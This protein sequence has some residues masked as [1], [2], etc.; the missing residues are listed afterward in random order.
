MTKR[1]FPVIEGG[2]AAPV[3]EGGRREFINVALIDAAEQVSIKNYKS[4]RLLI[5]SALRVLETLEPNGGA[6]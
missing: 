3:N 5:E 6:K 2:R 4:A 1:R